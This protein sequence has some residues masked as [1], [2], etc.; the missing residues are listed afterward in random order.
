MAAQLALLAGLASR[1]LAA[2]LDVSLAT[3][4]STG[5]Y[6]GT[7]SV[8]ILYVPLIAKLEIDAW[9]LK[10][11]LPFLRISGGTTTVEGPGGPIVTPAGTEEGFG[12]II[13]ESTYTF[14]PFARYAPFIEVGGRVKFPTAEDGLGT[15]EFDFT[16]EIELSRTFGRWTPYLGGG[17]RVLGDSTYTIVRDHHVIRRQLNYRDGFVANAGLTWRVANELLEPGMFVYWK[18]A[19]SSGADDAVEA[20]PVLRIRFAQAWTLDS[21]VSV[22]FT[23]SVPDVGTGVQLHYVIS[24]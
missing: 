16:P 10:L 15:G 14:D 21:Y 5:D 8:D 20:L 2:D 13:A 7:D 24:N 11:V 17:F 12:D 19:A 9:M 23:D 22:G 6:D 1:A 18:Q 4:Y 3:H